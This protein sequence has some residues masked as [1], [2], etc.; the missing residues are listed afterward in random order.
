MKSAESLLTKN[1]PEKYFL[2]FAERRRR[3]ET[4]RLL[5]FTAFR[6]A[7]HSKKAR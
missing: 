5:F 3:P 4:G 7:E 1:D 2:L 6:L